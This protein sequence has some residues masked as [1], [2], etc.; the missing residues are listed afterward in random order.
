MLFIIIII[1]IH[2][3]PLK[4]T[5]MPLKVPDKLYHV[6]RGDQAPDDD[7]DIWIDQ[8][9]LFPQSLMISPRKGS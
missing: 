9:V 2:K 6:Q 4:R 7:N 8:T 1:I 5:R 3:E